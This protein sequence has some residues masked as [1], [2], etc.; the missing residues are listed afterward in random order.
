MPYYMTSE[1]AFIKTYHKLKKKLVFSK[2][3]YVNQ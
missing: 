1:D 3:D 2:T